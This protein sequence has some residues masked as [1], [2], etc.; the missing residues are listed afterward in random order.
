[1]LPNLI[2]YIYIYICIFDKRRRSAEHCTCTI[3]TLFSSA[4]TW[5]EKHNPTQNAENIFLIDM[6]L[7]MLIK[8]GEKPVTPWNRPW[9]HITEHC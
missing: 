7:F 3:C 9:H 8:S 2:I 4:A 5:G 1:M 6:S